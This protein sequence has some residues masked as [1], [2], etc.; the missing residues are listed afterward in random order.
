MM[1]LVLTT[2]PRPLKTFDRAKSDFFFFFA[3]SEHE[4]TTKVTFGHLTRRVLVKLYSKKNNPLFDTD[5]ILS[6]K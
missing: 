1:S 5:Q 3:N 6:A 2:G 4:K